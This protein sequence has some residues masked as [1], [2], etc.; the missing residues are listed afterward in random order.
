MKEVEFY[1]DDQR[2][3]LFSLS[4][5]PIKLNYILLDLQFLDKRGGTVSNIFKVPATKN[6]NRIFAYYNDI[7]QKGA[8][9]FSKPRKALLIAGG[10][11]VFDGQASGK[12]VYS[13]DKTE[14]IEVILKGDNLDWSTYLKD[15]PIVDLS[16]P[17]VNYDEAT[18]RSSWSNT[19]AQGYTS[20][21]VCYGSPYNYR[22]SW[23]GSSFYVN[24]Y[25]GNPLK[26]QWDDFRYWLFAYPMITEMFAKAG[27]KLQSTFL[28]SADFK[29]L[30]LYYDDTGKWLEQPATI[31]FKT[32]VI[33][34]DRK[35]LDLL[36]GIA[37]R[38]NLM[39]RTDVERKTVY[40]E[41]FD[42]FFSG[43]VTVDEKV[44]LE[45]SAKMSQFSESV[46]N[47]VFTDKPDKF[48]EWYFNTYI[49]S[50]S[51]SFLINAY[52]ALGLFDAMP[53]VKG[54]GPYQG[55]L[56]FYNTQET[57]KI[58]SYFQGYM[59]GRIWL[60][61]SNSIYVPFIF[62]KEGSVNIKT[63]TSLPYLKVSWGDLPAPAGEMDPH[64]AYYA[65]MK[66][67]K[68]AG[69]HTAIGNKFYYAGDA[70]RSDRPFAFMCDYANEHNEMNMYYSDQW[71]STQAELARLAGI[72][73]SFST[74][75]LPGLVNRYYKNYLYSI[76]YGRY[77][78]APMLI[79]SS[80]ILSKI[81]TKEIEYKQAVWLMLEISGYNPGNTGTSLCKLIERKSADS[82][83][84][85]GLI[86]GG[87]FSY[88]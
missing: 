58:E 46:K 2:V 76:Y 66:P 3:D 32:D 42:N 28:E 86:Y 30:I 41:P 80:D 5:N 84:T 23:N 37:N 62:D 56:N 44:N 51:T 27:Y 38:F 34:P 43:R 26:W 87:S 16:L 65:G 9:N 8:E 53:Y 29:S 35:C 10:V 55:G 63:Q 57:T 6:N 40:V 22:I 12:A 78:E 52:G 67:M 68:D 85:N 20:P 21:L 33:S 72:P 64:I 79:K 25:S 77:V 4:D 70:A 48:S 49:L 71:N 81:F 82:S 73:F 11:T 69:T 74:Y 88:L 45:A 14:S 60:D 18:I 24:H 17:T 39:F 7:Q 31:N 75:K 59:T 19:Y 50:T 13:T 15:L 1:I 47:I 83:F 61:G 54:Q 36:K